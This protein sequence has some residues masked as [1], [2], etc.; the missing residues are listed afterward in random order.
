MEI[1]AVTIVNSNNNMVR[2][3]GK[4][5]RPEVAMFASLPFFYPSAQL[6]EKE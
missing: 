5:Q 2:K 1:K 6:A 3:A 4:L